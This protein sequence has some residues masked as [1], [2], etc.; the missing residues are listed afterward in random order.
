MLSKFSPL[1]LLN[2]A[3]NPKFDDTS[4]CVYYWRCIVQSLVFLTYFFKNY[5]REIFG[6]RGRLDPR[7][8]QRKGQDV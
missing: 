3:G 5:R 1:Y 4:L 8:L 2:F 7:P 6:E